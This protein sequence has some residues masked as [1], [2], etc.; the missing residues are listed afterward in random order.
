MV[1]LDKL[2]TGDCVQT[3]ARYA[4]DTSSRLRFRSTNIPFP[5]QMPVVPCGVPHTAEVF[6]AGD[7]WP[8][9]QKYPGLDTID[10]Q[11]QQRC[12]AEF[13]KYIGVAV[14]NQSALSYTFHT[15]DE[16]TWGT[17][18]D[19]RISCM[20][21]DVTGKEMKGSVKSTGK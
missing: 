18:D 19:R 15:P 21:Y 17:Q 9:S 1:P 12:D 3:P 6:F 8:A 2:S 10:R 7:N 4:K 20:A 13:K 14:S 5:D 16:A 11:S